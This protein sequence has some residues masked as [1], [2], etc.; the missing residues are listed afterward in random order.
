MDHWTQESVCALV[1][2]VFVCPTF[3][4][5]LHCGRC[6]SC[7]PPA[8]HAVLAATNRLVADDCGLKVALTLFVW[9]RLVTYTCLDVR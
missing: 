8:V 4:A 9:D 2:V 5:I 1:L 3:E 6:A 7:T